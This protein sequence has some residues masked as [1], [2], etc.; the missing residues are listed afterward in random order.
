MTVDSKQ[1]FTNRVADYVK[2]RPRYPEAILEFLRSD[3]GLA[4]TSVIADVGSGTGI[5]SELFL[6]NGKVVYG[7]EPNQAMRAAAEELLAAYPNFHS[8]DGASEAT[9]LEA[10]SVDF[11]T[12]GQA[13]HWFEPAATRREF[14]RILKPGGWIVLVWNSWQPEM[15]PFLGEYEQLLQAYAPD[16]PQ[17]DRRN[18]THQTFQAFFGDYHM[19]TFPNEQWLDYEG[20][21][22]RLLSSSYAPLSGHPNH[23]P[24]LAELRRLFDNYQ[25]AG[26]VRFEYETEVY[27]GQL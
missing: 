21:Q 18:V 8:I 1:R 27:Y 25:V 6:K 14:S 12:A 24:M 13:F 3:L 19:T 16:R 15:S 7:I 17:V 10:G 9:T 5:L 11:I 22:G 4:P 23:A 26:Q 20:L 2:Y